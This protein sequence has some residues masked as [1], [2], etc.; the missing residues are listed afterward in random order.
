MAKNAFNR[1]LNDSS[2]RSK[3]FKKFKEYKRLT[4]FKRRKYKEHLTNMLND[5]M[6]K[7]PQAAWKIIYEL[8]RDTV[9]TDNSERINRTE[10]YDHF[11]KLLTPQNGQDVDERKQ[12]VK[13]DLTNLENSSKTCNLDYNITEKEVLDACQKLKKNKA[14]S[15]DLIRNEML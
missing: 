11:K 4:K 6:D 10:W 12:S 5:A 3:Y 1:N 15:Y 9:Q 13:N 14:S 8:K 2:L 7:D